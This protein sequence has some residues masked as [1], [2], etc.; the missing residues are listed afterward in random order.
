MR[1]KFCGDLDCPDWL[2]AAI[3]DLA[4]LSSIKVRWGANFLAQCIA[5]GLTNEDGLSRAKDK[6][7]K[8]EPEAVSAINEILT[9]ATRNQ[10]EE[11]A[12]VDELQQLGLPREHSTAIGKAYAECRARAAQNLREVFIRRKG[13]I[14][15]RKQCID[16]QE[17]VAARLDNEDFIIPLGLAKILLQ[18]LREA[19]KI[20][21]T[22]ESGAT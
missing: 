14:S 7:D 5:D 2:L 19:R 18:D 21:E 3:S 22:H 4:K 20:L 1:F 9:L 6:L 10:V 15:F 16:G 17:F 13:S 8:L 12:L 11:T